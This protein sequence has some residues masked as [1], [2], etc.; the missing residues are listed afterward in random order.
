MKLKTK[1]AVLVLVSFLLG[2]LVTFRVMSLGPEFT[3]VIQSGSLASTSTYTAFRD[4]DTYYAKNNLNGAVESSS[5]ATTFYTSILYRAG[6]LNGSVFFKSFY[7]DLDWTIKI[8]NTVSIYGEGVNDGGHADTATHLYGTV[9]R[10]SK[11][12]NVFDIQG[13]IGCLVIKN[14]G[15][16]FTG[17]T[18]GNGIMIWNPAAP[19]FHSYAVINGVLENIAVLNNDGGHYAFYFSNFQHLVC[20]L[21]RSWGGPFLYLHGNDY[22]TQYGNSVFTECYGMIRVPIENH[23]VFI[24]TEGSSSGNW[25]NLMQFIRLQL[26][27]F[28]PPTGSSWETYKGAL[29]IKS[30]RY[31]MFHD[32]DIEDLEPTPHL[33]KV[34]SINDNSRG[35]VF[36]NPFFYCEAAGSKIRAES[37]CYPISFYDGVFNLREIELLAGPNCLFNPFFYGVGIDA[38]TRIFT[39]GKG[40]TVGVQAIGRD[41]TI[42]GGTTRLTV[43]LP[44]NA[45]QPDTDYAVFVTPHWNTSYW[46]E[47]HTADQFIVNFANLA[48]EPYGVWDWVIFRYS[49]GGLP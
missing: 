18:T 6:L 48:P 15:I 16:E 44:W 34:I 47:S 26:N 1:I 35:I 42:I 10:T 22:S 14:I 19:A 13:P 32:L 28:A 46:I 27:F 3:T 29:F 23:A 4:G 40:F 41:Y 17:A 12:I 33:V 43:T 8:N 38:P 25:T 30:G 9:F 24:W 11:A 39:Y 49:G 31:I 7:Y 36:M 21:L 5:N 45:Q 37:D 2:C 20:T